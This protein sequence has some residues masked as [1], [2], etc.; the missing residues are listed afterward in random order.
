MGKGEIFLQKGAKGR[1]GGE[2]IPA[3]AGKNWEKLD[4]C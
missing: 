1:E 4:E 2:R 3:V